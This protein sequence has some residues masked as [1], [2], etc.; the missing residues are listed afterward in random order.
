MVEIS[1]PHTHICMQGGE[2][3]GFGDLLIDYPPD[4]DRHEY[5]HDELKEEAYR[6]WINVRI[7]VTGDSILQPIC[8]PLLYDASS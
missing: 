7:L 5:S 3:E 2:E 8:S 1:Q 6:W 4:P